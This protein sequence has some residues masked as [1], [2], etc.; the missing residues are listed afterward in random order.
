MSGGTGERIKRYYS[1]WCQYVKL[2]KSFQ[3]AFVMYAF[4]VLPMVAPPLLR[5]LDRRRREQLVGRP[6]PGAI[7]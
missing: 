4:D 3:A 5:K 6:R 2:A 1:G 7:G